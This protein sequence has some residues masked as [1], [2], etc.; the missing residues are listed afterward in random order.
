[1]S[2]ANCPACAPAALRC[3]EALKDTC[4]II[5][6][7]GSG[8]RFG[9]PRGKQFVEVAGMPMVSWSVIA[10]DEAPCVGHIVIVCPLD[11]T[12]PMG[13]II[14]QLSLTTPVSFAEAGPTRQDSCR[15]GIAAVPDGFSFVAIH[16]GARPL[17]TVGA[18]EASV[19][20]LRADPSLDGAVCG[21]PAID[22][23]KLVGKGLISSTPDRSLFWAAQ[24]PQTFRI[25][26][27]RAAH[28]QAMREGF[29][30]TD[31]SSLVEHAGGRVA[32]VDSPRDNIK[33]TVPEDLKLVEAVLSE[34][35]VEAAESIPPSE[36]GR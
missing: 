27:I 16:D 1:M 17:V 28:E 11:R 6:A 31:D 25:D 3:H 23:L 5:A 29:V 7:G 12:E 20:A 33:V 8:E 26:V 18:I 19:Q 36:L 24:T 14:G 4:A 2:G 30:G 22:T 35:L 34:R 9:N 13:Q 21:Q 32:C 15:S 10:F